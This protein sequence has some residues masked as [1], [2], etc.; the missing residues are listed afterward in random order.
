[1]LVGFLLTIIAVLIFCLVFV[2][3]HLL[4]FAR[5]IMALEETLEDALGDFETANQSLDDLL[6]MQM[7]FESKEVKQLA[8]KA[9]EDVVLSKMAITR[10]IKSFTRLSKQQYEMVTVNDNDE[11]E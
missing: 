8:T 10:T 5:I 3:Y 1:M 4:R 9:L 11:N 2:G 6:K 7:F